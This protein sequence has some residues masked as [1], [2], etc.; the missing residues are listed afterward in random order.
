M[1]EKFI[2]MLNRLD[3]LEMNPDTVWEN[4]GDL[5]RFC[6]YRWN[7][8]KKKWESNQIHNIT[9]IIS[10][11]LAGDDNKVEYFNFL[12]MVLGDEE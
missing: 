1:T 3:E 6:N 10:F 5:G 8:K 9:A 2:K 12:D 7:D 4:Y 11:L